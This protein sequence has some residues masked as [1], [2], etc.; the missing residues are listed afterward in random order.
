[1]E[2]KNISNIPY[3]RDTRMV[4]HMKICQCNLPYPPYKQT[5]RKKS[6]TIS[7]DAELSS[8]KI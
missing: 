8:D 5:I 1:M 7:L 2:S 3:P 6:M 4:Y